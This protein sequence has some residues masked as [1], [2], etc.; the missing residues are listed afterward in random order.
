MKERG[1]YEKENNGGNVMRHI[2]CGIFDRLRGHWGG[3][4]YRDYTAVCKRAGKLWSTGGCC[5]A[6][7]H[8]SGSYFGGYG[9]GCSRGRERKPGRR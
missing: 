8:C 4:A 1:R 3:W 9:G 6:R 2:G 5:N 7:R